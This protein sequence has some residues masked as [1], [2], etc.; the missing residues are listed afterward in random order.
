M[1]VTAAWALAVA[2]ERTWRLARRPEPPRIPRSAPSHLA[3]ERT[4]D[5][6]VL[7]DVLCVD[8]APTSFVGAESW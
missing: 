4:D 8:P 6:T 3:T 5:L 7:R 1:P 2:A